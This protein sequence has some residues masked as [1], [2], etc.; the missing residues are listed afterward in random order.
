[1]YDTIVSMSPRL[2]YLLSYNMRNEQIC[3]KIS[4]YWH[5]V[6]LHIV[7]DSNFK[8]KLEWLIQSVKPNLLKSGSRNLDRPIFKVENMKKPP[9]VTNISTTM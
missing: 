7:G 8:S 5:S 3:K 9:G 6:S 1:M 2:M 4:I